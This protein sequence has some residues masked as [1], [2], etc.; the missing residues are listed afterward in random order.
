MC[1]FTPTGRIVRGFPGSNGGI[2]DN[3]GG[4]RGDGLCYGPSNY[5]NPAGYEQITLTGQPP[6]YFI[7]IEAELYTRNN[8]LYWT[9][10][11]VPERGYWAIQHSSYRTVDRML[12]AH[13]E[14]DLYLTGAT[15]VL[16]TEYDR[17]SWVSHH[18]FMTLSREQIGEPGEPGYEPAVPYGTN[19]TLTD[20][21]SEDNAPPSL[22]YE[23]IT[24]ADGGDGGW[25]ARDDT[26]GE[27]THIYARIQGG[28]VYW[29]V[30]DNAAGGPGFNPL[31]PAPLGSGT[32]QRDTEGYAHDPQY[33]GALA[34]AWRWT[35]LTGNNS[36]EL[37]L[38][39]GRKY[40]LRI[41]A[42][43]AGVDID[44]IV[45][46]NTTFRD[47]IFSAGYEAGGTYGETYPDNQKLH[48][49]PGSA[50]G[51]ACNRCNPIYGQVID[52]PDKCLPDNGYDNGASVVTGRYY[53][54]DT[55]V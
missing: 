11:R 52:D 54:P 47:R 20:A 36:S 26:T 7:V 45:I 2:G 10:Y 24:T 13:P 31:D 37:N 53:D 3:D 30:Y 38:E 28:D 42:G 40:T 17:G 39:P 49:T 51:Q 46:A 34:S 5:G 43:H 35:E 14:Y 19:Y 48:A 8:S 22:D 1:S 33:G 25:D 18:P 44:Q 55:G 6:Q 41:W 23:F 50:F 16:P 9:E 15:P 21:R 29:A 32:V 27:G 4:I 12:S